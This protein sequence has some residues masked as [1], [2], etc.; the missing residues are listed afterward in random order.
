MVSHT[1]LLTWVGWHVRAALAGFFFCRQQTSLACIDK[2]IK[3]G[4]YILH[5]SVSLSVCS[6]CLLDCPTDSL[7]VVCVCAWLSAVCCLSLSVSHKRLCS[8]CIEQHRKRGM[9]RERGILFRNPEQSFTR[10][11]V[12]SEPS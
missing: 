1:Q 12:F 4:E 7:C 2:C 5:L 11:D 9:G 8:V 6:L 10:K 3:E